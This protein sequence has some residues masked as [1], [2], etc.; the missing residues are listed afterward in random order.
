MAGAHQCSYACGL[1]STTRYAKD[2]DLKKERQ[3]RLRTAARLPE[4]KFSWSAGKRALVHACTQVDDDL[5]SPSR[6]NANRDVAVQEPVE[7]NYDILRVQK[8]STDSRLGVFAGR[9]LF[10]GRQIISERPAFSCIHWSKGKRTAA[11]E[12]LKLDH[13]HRENMRTWFRKLRN[14]P[15]GG[16]DTFRD[17]DKKRLENFVTDYAFWDPQRDQAH[18]Y[19]LSSHINHA[20]RLCANACFWVDSAYP[21]RIVVTLVR[22]VRHGDEIF[23]CYGKTNVPYGC[24]FCQRGQS[25]DRRIW[26]FIKDLCTRQ[27]KAEPNRYASGRTYH[28]A[29]ISNARP[30]SRTSGDSDETLVHTD[31]GRLLLPHS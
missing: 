11:E 6:P 27:Q 29:E 21:H 19:R 25:L 31:F 5:P 16:N 15:H 26:A 9:D 4:S 20:C 12:W 28:P 8:S 13:S 24:A 18:I 17:K 2:I 10:R 14:V 22:G 23:I 7:L 1:G 30:S 3:L